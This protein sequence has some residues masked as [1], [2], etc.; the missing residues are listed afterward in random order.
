MRMKYAKGYMCILCRH[1]RREVPTTLEDAGDLFALL[2][3]FWGIR[4]SFHSSIKFSI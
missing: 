2:L 1:Q 4:V 3:D